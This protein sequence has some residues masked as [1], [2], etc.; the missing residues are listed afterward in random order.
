MNNTLL[1]HTHIQYKQS[2]TRW[3]EKDLLEDNPIGLSRRTS[4]FLI[5]DLDCH[6]SSMFVLF[7]QYQKHHWLI[8][9]PQF[10]SLH[11][12]LEENY[13]QVHNHVDEVAERITVLGGIPASS[14]VAIANKAYIDHEEEGV[15]HVRD[16]LRLDLLHEQKIAMNLCRTIQ[17]AGEFGDYGT[18]HLL[19]K[20]LYAVENRAHHLDH[21]LGDDTLESAGKNIS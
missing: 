19:E 2:A 17:K 12:F 20:V 6:C 8:E 18:R 15:F 21:F 9:G 7:H 4:A 5:D 14:P 13:K 1:T 3:R 11:L 16:M 10:M